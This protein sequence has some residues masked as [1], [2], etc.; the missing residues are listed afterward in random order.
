[1]RNMQISDSNFQDL[2]QQEDFSMREWPRELNY[3]A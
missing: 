3:Q 1:M 2:Q